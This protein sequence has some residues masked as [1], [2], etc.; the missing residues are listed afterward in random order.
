MQHKKTEYFEM[1][2][3]FV[4]EYQ[5]MNGGATPALRV[6]GQ[7]IGLSESS[8]YKYVAAMKKQGILAC[9]G[10]KSIITKRALRDAEGFCRVP[11]LGAVAC[12]LPILAEENIEEYVKLP[13]ALFGKGN[14]YILRAKGESM[15]D[16]GIDDG[17]LVVVR[18]QDTADYNQIVVA[19][20]EDEATLK[21]YRPEAGRVVLHAENPDFEDIVVDDCAIQGVAVKVIKDLQQ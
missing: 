6:I 7:H 17:D 4:D 1:I 19:L 2:E 13:V 20:L 10:R 18:Q 15:V 8:V 5:A 11:V 3:C 12:G 14:F 21:R 9:D 16:A